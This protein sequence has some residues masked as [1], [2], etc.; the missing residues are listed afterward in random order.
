[1]AGGFLIISPE[2]RGTVLN[3]IAQ[4]AAGLAKYSP[5]SYAVV[6]LALLGGLM[7][8]FRKGSAPR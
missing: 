6:A 3:G 4:A 1:M 8:A 5:Y 7:A 2:L